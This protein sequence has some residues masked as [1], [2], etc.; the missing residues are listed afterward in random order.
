MVSLPIRYKLTILKLCY[1]GFFLKLF[2]KANTICLDFFFLNRV[3]IF[4]NTSTYLNQIINFLFHMKMMCWNVNPQ[5]FHCTPSFLCWRVHVP[6]CTFSPYFVRFFTLFKCVRRTL[7]FVRQTE[8]STNC[9]FF[10]CVFFFF[11]APC[12]FLRPGCIFPV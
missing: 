7:T 8:K 12:G 11:F 10:V 3:K 5:I 1:Y 6:L 4:Q 9:V 2:N